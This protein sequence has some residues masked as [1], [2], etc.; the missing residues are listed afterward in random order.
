MVAALCLELS[1][2]SG[3]YSYLL[4]NA[5]LYH[6]LFPTYK[7]VRTNHLKQILSRLVE[8]IQT[9]ADTKIQADDGKAHGQVSQSAGLKVAHDASSWSWYSAQGETLAAMS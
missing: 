2:R 1:V 9:K 7:A 5:W 4:V 3:L 6:T 8:Q